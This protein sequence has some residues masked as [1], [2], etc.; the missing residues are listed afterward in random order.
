MPLPALVVG[1]AVVTT[2][3]GLVDIVAAAEDGLMVVVEEVLLEVVT[4]ALLL[5]LVL[6]SGV[7]ASSVTVPITQYIWS[8]SSSEQFI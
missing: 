2:G 4:G 3:S 8:V 7:D 6:G 5:E 1:V